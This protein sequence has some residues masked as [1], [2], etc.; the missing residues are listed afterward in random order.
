MQ[1]AF[2]FDPTI[3]SSFACKIYQFINYSLDALSPW[4]L[5]Y[6]SV[7]K[8]I[9]IAFPSKRFIFK[10]IKNQIIFLVSLYL[11]NILYHLNVPFSVDVITYENISFC[12]SISYESQLIFVNMDLVNYIIL[13]FSLMI[14]F[15]ILLIVTIFKARRRVRLNDASRESKRLKQDIR[16]SISLI[17]MNLLFLILNL[18]IVIYSF[19]SYPDNSDLFLIIAY[20]CYL[21]YGVNFYLILLTNTLFRQEFFSLFNKKNARIIETNKT[22]NRLSKK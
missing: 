22:Q 21:S 15:S 2:N 20:M 18:P 16:F 1:N 17:S 11:F 6:V 5:V 13:P 9:A 7:E 8:F 4:C 12:T 14:I 3:L 10:S 19:I